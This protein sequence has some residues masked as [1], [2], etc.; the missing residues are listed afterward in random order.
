VIP[1][2]NSRDTFESAREVGKI[3]ERRGWRRYLLVTSA[4]HMPRSLMVFARLAREPIP[5]PG[6]FRAGR[7][8]WSPL[9]MWPSEQSAEDF[10]GVLNECLGIVN[11]RLRLLYDSGAP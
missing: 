4:R 5:A 3:L 11:Y 8:S 7:V 2:P 9:K 1:E 6:D 10:V